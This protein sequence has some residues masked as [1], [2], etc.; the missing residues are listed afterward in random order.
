M[1]LDE[2]LDS[3]ITTAQPCCPVRRLMDSLPADTVEKLESVFSSGVSTTKIHSVL[4]MEGY[5]I[6][7]DTLSYHRS[8]KC[9]CFAQ[10]KDGGK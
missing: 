6:G 10:K 1:G 3:L 7:R 8:G 4:R 2:T 9:R 5:A